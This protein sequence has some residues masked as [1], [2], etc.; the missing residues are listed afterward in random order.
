MSIAPYYIRAIID[1]HTIPKPDISST[2]LEELERDGM[3]QKTS[4]GNWITTA[5]GRAYVEALMEVPMP[6]QKWV[7]P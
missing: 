1:A 4:A 6:I 3:I 7:Q 2:T 5:K